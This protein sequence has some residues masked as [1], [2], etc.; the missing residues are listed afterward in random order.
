MSV[1][2]EDFI[3]CAL[4]HSCA[5][6]ADFHVSLFVSPRLTPDVPLD[7]L[8]SFGVFPHWGQTV[9]DGLRIELFDQA[10]QIEATPLLDEVDPSVWEA[11]FPPDTP[12]RG[13]E[14]PDW[15]GRRWRTFAAR[16][17]HDMGKVVHLATM[18]A[19][20]TT[21]PAPADHPLAEPLAEISR[22]YYRRDPHIP[23]PSPRQPRLIYD[24]SLMTRDLDRIVES[25]EPL[26]VIE[27]LIASQEPWLRR[28]ALELHRARRYYERPESAVPYQDRPT[29][30]AISPPV[31]RPEPEF[32]E[33][34]AMAGD[35]PALMRRLGLVIDLRVLDPSRLRQSRWLS[36]RLSP[37]GNPQP[38]RLTR[39]RCRAVGDALVTIAGTPDWVDGV[40][41]LGDEERFALLDLEADGTA[42]K[43]ERFLWTLPRLREVHEHD[44][45]AHAATPALRASGFTVVRTGQARDVQERLGVQRELDAMIGGGAVPELRTEEVARGLRVEVWDDTSRRWHSLHSRRTTV[46]VGGLG[47]V[48]DDVPEEGFIQ[49]TPAHETAG[50]ANSPVHVHEAMFGWE[51]WS[52]SAPRPGRRVRHENGDEI[53]EEVPEDEPDPVHPILVTNRVEPGTLPRLRFGR[54]YALRAWLV[55]LAG[56]VRPHV[57]NASAAPAE[58]VTGALAAALGGAAAAA[59]VAARLPAELRAATRQTLETRRLPAAVAFEAAAQPGL[60]A[61]AEHEALVRSRVG[62]LRAARSPL[63]AAAVGALDRRALVAEAVAAAVADEREVF[64]ADTAARSPSALASLV[65][66]Q[67]PAQPAESWLEAVR[68]ALATT[69]PLRPFLRWDPV[70]SP[71]VVPLRRY[72]EG[73]SVRVLVVR[74][75]V[76]Q[77]PDTL[78]LTVTPPAAYAAAVEAAHAGLDLGYA[79]DA[80]RHLAPPKTSQVQAELHGMFDEAIGSTDPDDHQRLLGIALRENGSFLD[81]DVAD[82]GDPPNRITQPGIRLETQ[83]GPQHADPITLPLLPPG[84]D[85]EPGRSDH[86][87]PGQYVVHDTEELALPYLPDPPARGVSFVFEEAGLDRAIPFPFGTEGFTARYPGDWPEVQPFRLVLD[88]AEQL[89]G[90]VDGRVI[91]ISLPPGDV[92]RFRL[93]SSLDRG[94]LALFGPWRSLPEA[95]RANRD[96]AEAAADGWLWGLTPSERFTLVHAVTRPLE[97]PRPTRILPLRGEGW[98]IAA[99]LGAVDVHGP[100]TDRLTA[101]ARWSERVDDITLPIWERRD[102]TGVAFTS[103]VRPYEDL[104]ILG[105]A[106]A[107]GPVPGIGQVHVHAAVHQ[108]GDTKHRL[109]DYRFRA[110]T[111]FPEY[112][113]ADLLAP[114]ED[115]AGDDGRSVVGPW[116]QVSIPS[117]ARPAAPIVHSVIPLLRWSDGTE[118][119]QPVARRHGRRAGVRI[120]LER[121][122]Y[123]SGDGE[124]LGVLLAP[125]G[126]DTFPPQGDDD[127]GFPFVSKWGGDPVWM[128]APVANRALGLL[129]LDNLLRSVGL[130][131]RREAGRPVTPLALLPL[132]SLQNAPVVGVVG[133]EPQYNAERKLWY[134][135]VALDPGPAFWPFVRLAVCRYQP[136]SVARCHLSAPVRCDYVQLLPERTTS[137]SRT[138]DRHVRVV[139]SGPVGLRSD[140]RLDRDVPPAERVAQALRANRHLIAR[141]QRRDPA[142]PT[143]LG[144]E[145]VAVTEL[146]ARGRGGNEFEA[147]WVGELDAGTVIPLVRP[148]ANP[149]WRVAVEEWERLP[150]DPR[151]PLD[152]PPTIV[153]L[154]VW[155]RR[156]VYADEI[157]L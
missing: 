125:Q 147:A 17:V 104:A 2:T 7:E 53:V 3:V 21:P 98:T 153:P 87:P 122:W 101:E 40:A 143:D 32:H 35:H 106:D 72:T 97:A 37:G 149:D 137:V 46:R 31:D 4:P 142:I 116:V 12:V 69:T 48:L 138:D 85:P 27:R 73:E 119:E 95:V 20:P 54:S 22:E 42:L 135:D 157:P 75:G 39:V 120:F 45:P 93:S 76:A 150:G 107:E 136:D 124:L 134:V 115:V 67:L 141:L 55:D 6:Q 43:L 33:R 77:D 63:A 144:W 130:D 19:D 10:G 36:A 74:S 117:S 83:P 11:A 57:L 146:V 14:L 155:E 47:P 66:F 151:S 88:G 126:D 65:A 38:C 56:N 145:T 82:L 44:A 148:G 109:I 94:E 78:E 9:Q 70:P 15:G 131:D 13:R 30:G 89:S 133:Y 132:A 64:V 108:L 102:S 29:P 16:T 128:S 152:G 23:G 90:R 58:P 1:A 24:E 79:G 99:L 60:F 91:A 100:S 86:L 127:S 114:D 118:P 50:V 105:L 140:L 111:R 34:C 52:L 18:Y 113:H 154:P 41:R 81:L 62:E 26:A 121:S 96:V 103:Q 156:L 5:E 61:S 59:D 123:S 68:R 84:A 80:E 25:G 92:Q 129:Q 49:G 112:F 8:R 28:L 71:A 110:L 51:G 139:V